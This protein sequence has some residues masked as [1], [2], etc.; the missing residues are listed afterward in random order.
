MHYTLVMRLLALLILLT[1][2][3][4]LAED[5]FTSWAYDFF[6]DGA[7]VRLAI[8]IRQ[9]GISVTRKSDGAEGKIVQRK[10]NSWFLS[11]STKP[12]YFSVKNTGITLM[13]NISSFDADQ[14]DLGN[15]N[16]VDLGTR[17][18][19]ESYYIVPTVF[20]EWGDYYSGTY[21]RIGG[22][23]GAGLATYSGNL[24]LTST[25]DNE[26][27]SQSQGRTNLKPVLGFM[28][29]LSLK[30]WSLLLSTAGPSYESDGFK[31]NVEDLSL[32]VGYR[33][34]F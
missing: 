33:F 7:S 10:T 34:M 12:T 27:V 15:D 14:Q 17:L 19:G 3:I 24:A 28:I 21:A 6:I 30:H 13:F 20:Y 16:F 22:G 32:N 11:Y 25:P 8:G 18:S 31:S 4:V 1:P 29:E 2:S 9:A 5:D 26:I 23:L